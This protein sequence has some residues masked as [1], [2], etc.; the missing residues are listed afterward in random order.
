MDIISFIWLSL[1]ITIII[2][3]LF[4][5][6]VGRLLN[7]L[8]II[9]ILARLGFKLCLIVSIGLGSPACKLWVF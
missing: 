1:L 3:M 6:S 8:W 2:I 7:Y 9:L 5:E 4:L